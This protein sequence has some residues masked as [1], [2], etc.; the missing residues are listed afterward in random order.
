MEIMDL[1]LRDRRSLEYGK[2]CVREDSLLRLARRPVLAGKQAVFRSGELAGPSSW[3]AGSVWQS[4][5]SPEQASGVGCLPSSDQ[6]SLGIIYH[7]L[8]TGDLE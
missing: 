6:Y 2:S 3:S 5:L 1:I 8:L 4:Y 7:E